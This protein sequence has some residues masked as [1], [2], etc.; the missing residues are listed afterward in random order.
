MDVEVVLFMYSD[1]VV[2]E[3]EHASYLN[4]VWCCHIL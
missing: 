3:V 1:L 2:G 4:C